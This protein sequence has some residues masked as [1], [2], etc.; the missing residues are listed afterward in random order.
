[1]SAW[2]SGYGH[3]L[4]HESREG[5]SSSPGAGKLDSGEASIP[6]WSGKW[7]AISK[8]VGDAVEVYEIEKYENT[9][10]EIRALRLRPAPVKHVTSL[11]FSL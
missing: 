4:S 2:P 11:Y 5:L 6:N 1:M 3:R 7:V 10:F 9:V 8:T